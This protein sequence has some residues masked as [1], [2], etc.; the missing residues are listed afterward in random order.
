MKC[1]CLLFLSLTFIL[2]AQSQ[3]LLHEDFEGADFPPAGW[4]LV[5]GN[6]PAGYNWARNTDSTLGYVSTKKTPYPTFQGSGSIVYEFDNI[7]AKAWAITPALSLT[8]GNSYTITF[9]YAVYTSL[10]PE[11]LKVTVGNAATIEAQNSVLWDN[12]GGTQL[13]ND[14]AWIKAT[15]SYTPA[16]SG[17]FY[18]GFN[19]YSDP[20]MFALMIDNIKVEAAP[21]AAPPCA[22]LT[23]PGNGAVNISAPQALFTW[24]SASAASEYEFKLGTT[25]STESADV[26]TGKAAFQ[27][28]LA[29]NTTYYWTVVPKNAAGSAA[30]CPVYSF[31]TQPVPPLPV[32][33]ECSGAIPLTAGSPLNASSRSATQSM[34]AEACNG[35]TGNANDDVWFKFTAS[36]AGKATIILT[37]DLMFDGVMHAYSGGCNSLVGLACADLNFNGEPDTLTLSNVISG[38]TYYFRVYGFDD[39]GEDGSFTLTVSE[40][41]SESTLPVTITNFKGEHIGE[42]NVLLWTTLTEQNN[43]GFE[44]QR[45]ANGKDFSMVAFIESKAI[46]GNS[47]SAIT[48]EFTDIKPFAA[49]SFYRLKQV[50]KDGKS[51]LSDVVFL[52]GR[53]PNSLALSNVYPN[54]AKS[55][56]N[57]VLAA[58]ALTKVSVIVTDVAGKLMMQ[59]AAQLL[60]G[61]NR[62]SLNVNALPPGTYLIKA[63]G[64]NGAKAAVSKFVKQ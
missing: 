44:L 64:A 7:A 52:K 1:F 16:S 43:K 17:N 4:T 59:Q 20:E 51:I 61:E 45:S 63:A 24:D 47:S 26:L 9:Y 36:Q 58:P 15:I 25:H 8:N 11:K 62:L 40:T 57:L 54:P 42:Q 33:D 21:A 5:N 41:A 18:F 12:N 3:T 14:E 49:N 28:D 55:N 22:A 6:A 10:Y 48:Y 50:D 23:A 30:G 35:N 2:F 60:N 37:P 53:Q 38:E 13:T 19:C 31:T 34:T 27:S 39:A 29:Y 46:D 32:N 56:V